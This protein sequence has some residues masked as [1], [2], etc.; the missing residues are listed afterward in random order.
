MSYII[1]D[2]DVDSSS[3]FPFRAMTLRQTHRPTNS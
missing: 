3:R 2:F 1:T